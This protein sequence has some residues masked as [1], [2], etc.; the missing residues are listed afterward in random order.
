MAARA[1]VR[2]RRSRVGFFQD[3]VNL[4]RSLGLGIHYRKILL[5]PERLPTEFGLAIPHQNPLWTKTKLF[6]NDD[7]SFSGLSA[8]L[9]ENCLPASTGFMID[10]RDKKK[11][12]RYKFSETK[13]E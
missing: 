3:S 7:T 10:R 9:L 2:F 5:I 1:L 8:M 12:R 4:K 6:P 11:A 13:I